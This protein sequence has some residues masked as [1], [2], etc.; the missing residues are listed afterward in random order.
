MGW[1]DS[2]RNDGRAAMPVIEMTIRDLVERS[3]AVL[4][5]LAP[6]GI[7]LCCGGAHRLG[8]ALDVHGIERE[9]V[10]AAVAL[11]LT[12]PERGR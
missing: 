8:P 11:A 3:P 10:V 9:P 1:S 12:E 7:D 6:L 2:D 4:E 5:I